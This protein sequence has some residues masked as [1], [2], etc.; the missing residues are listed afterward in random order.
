MPPPRTSLWLGAALLLVAVNLRLPIAG[1][2]PIVDD[3][4]A[5]LGLSAAAA[6]AITTLPVLCFAVAAPL[7]PSLGRRF[8]DEPV[9]LACLLLLA[10]GAAVRLVPQALPFY[11]GTLVLG[12]GIALANV[13]IPSVIKRWFPRPGAM[14]GLYVTVMTGG[15]AVAAAL[16]VPLARA[17]GSWEWALAVWGAPSLLAAVV[18]LPAIRATR[19]VPGP[20]LPRVSLWR[21]RTAWLLTAMMGCQGLLFY[22][23]L[24][25]VPEIVADSG[26]DAGAAGVMLSIAMLLGIPTSLTLPVLAGRT[27]D[28]RPLVAVAGALWLAG[29]GGLLLS[30]AT[31]T[32]AWMVLIGLGQGGGFSLAMALIV[33]RAADGPHAA[34]L[35]GMVQAIGYV[36]AGLGPFAVGAIHD[37]TGSWEAPLGFLVA[38]AF[39]LLASGLGA[40][41]PAPVAAV[42]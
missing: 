20:P 1:V 39:G 24:A 6:G 32:A 23:V 27:D 35:S 38:V 3:V 2:P 8:G 11:A 25:W 4:S 18:W 40:A 34:G 5:G 7:A 31:G 42:P 26:L 36:I 29:L 22:A 16:T 28:Q 14:T 21:D 13:L 41:R 33:L 10:A 9:I 19:T 17:T 37:A 30:P 12:L 15:A